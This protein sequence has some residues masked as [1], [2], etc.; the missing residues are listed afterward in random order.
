MSGLYELWEQTLAG[1][2]SDMARNDMYMQYFEAEEGAY[3]ILL[4]E[5]P[6]K[7]RYEGTISELA[8][9][10]GLEPVT[11]TVFID[12]INTSLRAPITLADLHEDTRV[13]LDVDLPM[14]YRNMLDAKAEHLYTLPQWDPILTPE[15][16]TQ[17][18]HEWVDSKQAK[19]PVKAGRND[20]CPCG[21]GKKYKK[22]CWDKDHAAS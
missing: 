14:L 7:T 2:P 12:G 16:R 5:A 19:N 17:I 10:F 6:E 21:S 18:R 13:V 8:E 15:E 1:L 22:C 11:F 9:H 3:E 20:P 4:G